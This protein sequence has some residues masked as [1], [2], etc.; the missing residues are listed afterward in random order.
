M[1][2][3]MTL[4]RRNPL[5]VVGAAAAAGWALGAGILSIPSL[6]S[7]SAA[8]PVAS[9]SAPAPAAQLVG[10]SSASMPIAA[11]SDSLAGWNV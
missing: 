3:L 6:P 10:T 8:R 9:G 4:L 1:H 11:P 5:I 7:T 2:E